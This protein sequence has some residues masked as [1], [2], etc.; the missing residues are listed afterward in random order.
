M[1][2]EKETPAITEVVVPPEPA[3]LRKGVLALS[4]RSLKTTVV[5][6]AAQLARFVVAPGTPHVGF[7]VDV[8]G[9]TV[10]G[11][12]NAKTLRRV[13]TAIA[14]HGPESV[15][16]IVQGNLVGERLDAAGITAQPRNKAP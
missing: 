7:T 2:I 10:A 5:V 16:V 9:R 13:V 12:F 4:A 11:Q 15:A 14:E 8:N 1:V 6:P 3:S